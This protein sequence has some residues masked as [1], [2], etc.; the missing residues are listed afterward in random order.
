M[1]ALVDGQQ[2]QIDKIAEATEE[3]RANARSGLDEIQNG[4]LGLCGPVVNSN[5]ADGQ[6]DNGNIASDEWRVPFETLRDDLISMR[7]DVHKFGQ[8]LM[9][10]IQDNV[11][12]QILSASGCS[13]TFGC[14]G[15]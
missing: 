2:E 5:I 8:R 9:D 13:Q 12:E 15:V 10:D 1:A 4:I 6:K 11:Q 14:D 7:T 3:S